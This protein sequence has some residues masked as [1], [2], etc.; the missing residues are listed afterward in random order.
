[1]L[2]DVKTYKLNAQ[3]AI[4][5]KIASEIGLG[6]YYN[7]S[8]LIRNYLNDNDYLWYKNVNNIIDNQISNLFY[9]IEHKTNNTKL[10]FRRQIVKL[11]NYLKLIGN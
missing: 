3:I 4:C 11:E 1:M 9:D 2:K 10:F 7:A 5:N 8:I 6:H